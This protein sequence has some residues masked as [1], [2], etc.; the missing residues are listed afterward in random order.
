[1][2]ISPR[3]LSEDF[4]GLNLLLKYFFSHNNIELNHFFNNWKIILYLKRECHRQGHCIIEWKIIN[5]NCNFLS[6]WTWGHLVLIAKFIDF[7]ER[8]VKWANEGWGITHWEE[9]FCLEIL[10]ILKYTEYILLLGNLS[11]NRIFVSS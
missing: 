8:E 6:A 2:K 1:M 3:E 9:E 4:V 7:V 11:F 10:I 5:T